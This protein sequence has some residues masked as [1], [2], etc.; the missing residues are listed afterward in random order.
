MS[1][2]TKHTHTQTHTHTDTHRHTDTHTHT[3][4]HRHTQTHTHTH[5]HTHKQTKK[6]T[7]QG[8]NHLPG[9]SLRRARGGGGSSGGGVP[10]PAGSV[11]PS[12]SASRGCCSSYLPAASLGACSFS[13]S[14]LDFG[15]SGGA[16]PSLS[17]LTRFTVT[18]HDFAIACG[19]AIG[20]CPWS[21]A[22][23]RT[24]TP[25]RCPTLAV[26][27]AAMAC[28]DSFPGV[29]DSEMALTS[30]CPPS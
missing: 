2:N 11:L 30:C 27:D 23:E 5:T 21:C 6:K 16:L 3:H 29:A 13:C 22:A 24:G 9:G 1:S 15:G 14:V 12:P 8:A 19:S 17:C 4:T 25:E 20:P 18:A 26:V 7:K 28:A 10:Y